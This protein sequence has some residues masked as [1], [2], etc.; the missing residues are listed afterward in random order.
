M[1]KELIDMKVTELLDLLDTEKDEDGA[2]FQELMGKIPF[3]SMLEYESSLEKLEARLNRIEAALLKHR[4][5]TTG[6]V[7]GE[8]KIKD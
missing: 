2:V 6:E 7:V 4:H 1:A 8:I 5:L 3:D